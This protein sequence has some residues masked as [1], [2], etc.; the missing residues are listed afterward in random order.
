[1]HADVKDTS[2]SP[3]PTEPTEAEILTCMHSLLS[4]DGLVFPKDKLVLEYDLNPGRSTLGMSDEWPRELIDE[5][6]ALFRF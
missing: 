4:W 5:I 1:V 2:K 6:Y 3:I